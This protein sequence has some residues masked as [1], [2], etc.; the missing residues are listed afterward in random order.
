MEGLFLETCEI[1][2]VIEIRYGHVDMS[3][4]LI[5]H[6]VRVRLVQY[7]LPLSHVQLWVMVCI[8]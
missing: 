3:V 6:K 7:H 4:D 1:I 8:L 2:C 5:A